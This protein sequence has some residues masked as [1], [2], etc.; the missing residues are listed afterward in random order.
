MK[1]IN[2]VLSNLGL[3]KNT[4]ATEQG[5]PSVEGCDS[6]PDPLCSL[7]M[8]ET[9]SQ[10]VDGVEPVTQPKDAPLQLLLED[11]RKRKK[12]ED[13]DKKMV[14]CLQ[15]GF[16]VPESVD[17]LGLTVG[18]CSVAEEDMSCGTNGM[19]V[20]V[21]KK[22]K[23]TAARKHLVG[24]VTPRRSPHV[25]RAA[26][27]AEEEGLALGGTPRRSPR[28]L[29]TAA[30]TPSPLGAGASGKGKKCGVKRKVAPAKVNKG[31]KKRSRVNLED[32]DD[33]DFNVEDEDDDDAAAAA[34]QV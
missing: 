13:F 16:D 19:V 7:Q 1:T 31:V 4:T 32:T 17:F 21:K 34:N 27:L 11:Q 14:A 28:V 3:S 26:E 6:I 15:K 23:K 22:I 8:S 29:A 5:A 33:A 9:Q 20:S 18:H 12:Q 30:P 24:E 25:S 2:D 10:S